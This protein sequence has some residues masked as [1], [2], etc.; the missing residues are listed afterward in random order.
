MWWHN[1][2]HCTEERLALCLGEACRSNLTDSGS[3]IYK[4]FHEYNGTRRLTD[5]SCMPHVLTCKPQKCTSL[6]PIGLL[7]SSSRLIAGLD[8][9]C[10]S[11]YTYTTGRFR[12]GT[13]SGRGVAACEREQ[14]SPN[15]P[16]LQWQKPRM[17]WPRPLHA[18]GHSVLSTCRCGT[19]RVAGGFTC[20]GKVVDGR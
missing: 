17:H 20:V 7:T 3:N 12:L 8:S 6:T 1:G 14:S 10:G 2:M 9:E 19:R 15:Q 16:R 13:F 11:S 18:L 5:A 4:L